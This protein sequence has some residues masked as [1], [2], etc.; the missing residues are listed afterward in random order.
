M[1]QNM[2][3]RRSLDW[4]VRRDSQLKQLS[5]GALVETDVTSLLPNSNPSIALESFNKL[6]VVKTG[7]FRHKLISSISASGAKSRSSSTGSK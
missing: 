1:F 5:G 2:G 4:S 7:N 6:L 3:K